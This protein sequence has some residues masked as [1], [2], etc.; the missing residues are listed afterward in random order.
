MGGSVRHSRKI[1]ASRTP[2]CTQPYYTTVRGEDALSHVPGLVD[3][4]LRDPCA[5]ARQV[6]RIPVLRRQVICCAHCR[7]ARRVGAGDN[8]SRKIAPIPALE[9]HAPQAGRHGRW[10]HGI[11][12]PLVPAHPGVRQRSL[13]RSSSDTECTDPSLV[14]WEA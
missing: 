10:C 4:F 11:M 12:M 6:F 3:V 5:C 2:N 14:N 7:L 13:V 9:T 8:F 1:R